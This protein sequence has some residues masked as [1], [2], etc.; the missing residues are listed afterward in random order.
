M[1]GTTDYTDGTDNGL[2]LSVISVV[3]KVK[4]FLA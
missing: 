2:F 4:K 3:K 1:T